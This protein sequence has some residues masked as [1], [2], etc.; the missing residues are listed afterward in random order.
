MNEHRYVNG[1]IPVCLHNVMNV[2]DSD[3]L[4]THTR[5]MFFVY[6][7]VTMHNDHNN[8]KCFLN[9]NSSKDKIFI[10]CSSDLDDL[11]SEVHFL[12]VQDYHPFPSKVFA[13]LYFMLQGP[14]PVVS[15]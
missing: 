15:I 11:L 4:Q 7:Y 5:R 12:D 3:R 1:I 2:A 6:S 8:I 14:R 10:C 9:Y 13:L